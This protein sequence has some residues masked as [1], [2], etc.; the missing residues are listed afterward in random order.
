MEG[1][2]VRKVRRRGCWE[3]KWNALDFGV[4]GGGRPENNREGAVREV[5]RKVRLVGST[6]KLLGSS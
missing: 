2:V 1:D 5:K 4:V 6:S 3:G